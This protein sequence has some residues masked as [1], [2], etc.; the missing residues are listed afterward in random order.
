MEL[1]FDPPPA[2]RHALDQLH[3]TVTASSGLTNFGPADYLPGLKTLLQS[4]DYDPHFSETGRRAA[5]T[6]AGG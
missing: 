5:R 2:F 6:A 3:E 1:G 4:M